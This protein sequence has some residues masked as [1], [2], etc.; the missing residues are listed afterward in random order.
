MNSL[1]TL[2][3][4][5]LAVTVGFAPSFVRAQEHVGMVPVFLSPYPAEGGTI[6]VVDK[7]GTEYQDYPLGKIAIGT[8]V[9]VTI[10]PNPGY[11]ISYI[12]NNGTE[13]QEQDGS[14]DKLLK[15][16]RIATF[17]SK[18]NERKLRISCN[19][20]VAPPVVQK[21]IVTIEQPA[22]DLGKIEVEGRYTKIPIKNGQ[23][24]DLNDE[25]SVRVFEYDNA[26]ISMLHVG[27]KSY[28][29]AELEIED[30]ACDVE[31]T[32]TGNT[33]IYCEYTKEETPVS[34][35]WQTP[36]AAEGTL[37]VFDQNKAPLSSGALLTKGSLILLRA[38]P[39]EAYKVE[40]IVVGSQYYSG[41][42][43]LPLDSKTK[44]IE[45]VL[46]ENAE[47][48]VQFVP[49]EAPSYV[50]NFT[51]PEEVASLVTI[52]C[53]G[54]AIKSGDKAK[55]GDKLHFV[56]KENDDFTTKFWRVNG[57]TRAFGKES[58]D[59]DMPN[60]QLD[61]E[62]VVQKVQRYKVDF[63]DKP[64]GGMLIA[65]CDGAV[66]DPGLKVL[67]GKTILFSAVPA[68]G[69][70]I[71]R[72]LHNGEPVNGQNDKYQVIVG[73][74]FKVEVL[75]ALREDVST[76]TEGFVAPV[77]C[78]ISSEE[79]W[80][81]ERSGQVWQLISLQGDLLASGSSSRIDATRLP[82]GVYLLRLGSET[83]KLVKP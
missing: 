6:K 42:N 3:I 54:S 60:S 83:L 55:E 67:A 35:S 26:R 33:K 75:F 61:V 8:E 49:V 73:S 71:A 43:L 14:L 28:P 34:V 46:T 13:Y 41:S 24:V 51:C 63:N 10:T 7:N 36:N 80:Q 45:V 1:R 52:S 62:L 30:G 40:S 79:A 17:P 78:Y 47:I 76:P 64:R 29:R 82:S 19:F 21:P 72:W 4:T 22:A 44:S 37:E 68:D 38:T 31:Y 20:S 9:T 2:L 58:L 56:L 77:V 48:Q 50:V 18:A 27:E 70:V 66:V 65:T 59:V 57:Y 11:R 39:Q 23:E 25:I 32:V 81:L 74:D 16:N 69:Y 15:G 53:N 5:L 12:D